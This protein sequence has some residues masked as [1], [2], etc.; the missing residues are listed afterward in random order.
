[1]TAQALNEPWWIDVIKALIVPNLVL[2]TF[3]YLTLVE[4]KLLLAE[5]QP[6][7]LAEQ[8]GGG[9]A[10]DEVAVEDRLHLILEP[11]ALTDDVG[12]ARYLAAERMRLLVGQPHRRQVR[13]RQ[14]TI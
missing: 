5:P 8:V 3:A 10:R 12:A 7:L 14:E 2:G 6:P 4:R 11:R 13:K 9:A 1:M